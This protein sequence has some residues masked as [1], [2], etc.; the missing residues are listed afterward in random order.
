MKWLES[1][2]AV[3]RY[4]PVADLLYKGRFR[5]KGQYFGRW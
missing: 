2:L 1:G 5:R 3:S 4:Y